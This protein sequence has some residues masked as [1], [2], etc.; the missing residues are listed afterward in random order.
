MRIYGLRCDRLFSCRNVAAGRSEQASRLRDCVAFATTKGETDVRRERQLEGIAQVKADPR[1]RAEK[2]AGRKP[3]VDRAAVA[4]M[5]AEG[6]KPGAI[7]KAV[8]A[9]RMTVWRIM[10]TLTAEAVR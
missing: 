4:R 2:Y 10:E 1:A 7:A 6:M 5:V 9:S 8:G 3:S